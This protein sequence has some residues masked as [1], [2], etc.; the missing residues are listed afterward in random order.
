VHINHRGSSTGRVKSTVAVVNCLLDVNLR[1]VGDGVE[2]Q[3]KQWNLAVDLHPPSWDQSMTSD[4]LTFNRCEPCLSADQITALS[5][6]MISLKSGRSAGSVL[7]HLCREKSWSVY[8]NAVRVWMLQHSPLG[9]VLEAHRCARW[10]LGSE[11]NGDLV[12]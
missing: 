10:E 11:A 7:Q 4:T 8:W 3:G 6:W 12:T 5:F 2:F 9:Q 1:H